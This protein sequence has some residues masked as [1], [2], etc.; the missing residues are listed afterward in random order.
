SVRYVRDVSRPSTRDVTADWIERSVA[1]GRVVATLNAAVGL[2]P[3]RFETLLVS[4][5]NA[6]SRIQ[7]VNADLVVT[8][9][10]ADRQV[11]AELTRLFVAEPE[12]PYSGARLRVFAPPQA[13]RPAYEPLRL[14]EARL[15]ASERPDLLS[16]LHD[17]SA[18]STWRTTR[19]QEPGEW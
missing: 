14:E 9:P 10:G 4:G 2:D 18:G 16:A 19:D 7:A 12:T 6:R 13:L 1:S 15:A 5:L 11:L 3:N 8:G 17:G